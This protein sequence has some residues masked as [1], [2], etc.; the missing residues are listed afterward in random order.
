MKKIIS[1]LIILTLCLCFCSCD[2]KLNDKETTS[3][4]HVSVE[5]MSETKNTESSTVVS[6]KENSNTTLPDNIGSVPSTSAQIEG[7]VSLSDIVHNP[8]K[9]QGAEI[10]TIFK[11]SQV[12]IDGNSYILDDSI[13]ENYLNKIKISFEYPDDTIG[14]LKEGEL[15]KVKG[16]YYDG[17]IERA[18]IIERG[19]K[20]EKEHDKQVKQNINK[21]FQYLPSL[22]DALKNEI[23][24]Q[25]LYKATIKITDKNKCTAECGDVKINYKTIGAAGEYNFNNNK[26]YNICCMAS[27]EQETPFIII[28]NVI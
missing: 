27:P 28:T 17:Y 14:N 21:E 20:L 25:T 3:A 24:E 26:S 12:S 2:K 6:S 8:K 19:N 23:D 4:T 11:V 15:I 10:T 18:E 9:Y 5:S 1:V 13:G 22:S 16:I 7:L